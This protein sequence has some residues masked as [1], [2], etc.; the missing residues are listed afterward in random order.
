MNNE[1]DIQDTIDN[2]LSELLEDELLE[3]SVDDTGEFYY[4]LNDKGKKVAESIL[5][6]D[7]TNPDVQNA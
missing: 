1:K 5:G 4:S 2:A 6:I 3:I 7:K